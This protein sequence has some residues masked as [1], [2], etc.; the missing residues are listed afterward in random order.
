MP[1]SPKRKKHIC[2]GPVREMIE[3]EV[4]K[5]TTATTTNQGT[6]HTVMSLTC[7]SKTTT[8]EINPKGKISLDNKPWK[9]T[10]PELSKYLCINIIR[11]C[12]NAQLSYQQE[13]SSMAMYKICPRTGKLLH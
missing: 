3:A 12:K 11:N 2:E 6:L 8:I 9:G 13:Y 10:L 5:A 7:G 1:A 4:T